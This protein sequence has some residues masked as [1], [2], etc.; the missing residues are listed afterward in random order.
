MRGQPEMRNRQTVC[1]FA[2]SHGDC[3]MN[4]T[5]NAAAVQLPIQH[6]RTRKCHVDLR[7]SVASA[8]LAIA[9]FLSAVPC[10]VRAAR[11]STGADLA[12]YTQLSS[13]DNS[14]TEL[15]SG[16]SNHDMNMGY[17]AMRRLA[18]ADELEQ[19]LGNKVSAD[20][21]DHGTRLLIAM[22]SHMLLQ[23]VPP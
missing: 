7:R 4:D 3:R 12:G 11:V 15:A 21:A 1:Q 20:H 23:P 2:R 19:L 13:G 8:L 16:A 22:A 6:A 5:M 14:P 9:A 18:D 17:T 10:G